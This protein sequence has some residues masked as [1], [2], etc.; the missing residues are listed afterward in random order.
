MSNFTPFTV[1]QI[2]NFTPHWKNLFLSKT[3]QT[4]MKLLVTDE[5]HCIS[6]SESGDNFRQE[7]QQL[8]ELR[9]FFQTPVMAL[10]AT[11]T[12]KVKADIT[13]HLHLSDEDTDIVYKSPDRPNIF[14]QILKRESS[15]YEMSLG[16]LIDHIR[17]NGSK[18]KKPIIYCRSIDTVSE[19]FLTFKDSLGADAYFDK[20]KQADNILVEMYHKSTH[21]DS[22]ERILTEF[23]SG[24]SRIR[25]IIATVALGMGLDIRDEQFVVH[26]GCP[27]S[28]IS[29]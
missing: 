28:I 27:K 16:W 17:L 2:S 19:I 23:K 4:R 3:W 14:I 11:S 25:C 24:S 15:E 13:T 9:S 7:Y 5:A 26:I 29:Y 10:T 22:K 18:S 8:S 21:Q 6:E 20:K 1:Q 12:K